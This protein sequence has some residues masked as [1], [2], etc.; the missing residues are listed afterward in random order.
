MLLLSQFLM[1]ICFATSFSSW[2]TRIQTA[3]PS[4]YQYARGGRMN[5]YLVNIAC[6]IVVLHL[7]CS[8][9]PRSYIVQALARCFAI[10]IYWIYRFTAFACLYFLFLLMSSTVV[11]LKLNWAWPLNL[12]AFFIVLIAK[13]RNS[14]TFDVF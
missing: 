7:L 3:T 13:H 9:E 1:S 8:W 14:A 4:R 12:V 10:P 11:V 5:L 2:N 6:V